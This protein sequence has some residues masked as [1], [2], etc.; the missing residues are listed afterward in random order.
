MV[1]T[2]F[3][4]EWSSDNNVLKF[5]STLDAFTR[6]HITG[7]EIWFNQAHSMHNSYFKAHPA[8]QNVD[9]D[10]CV[11]PTHAAYGDGEEFEPRYLEEIRAA[12]WKNAVGVSLKRGD[13]IVLDNMAVQ[14]ARL[15][16]KGDRK[17]A[18][19]LLN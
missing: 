7:E 12:G 13:L 11:F 9:T 14:H 2:G 4:W 10:Q 17:M 19:A 8:F 18:L 1:D 16:F 15:S 6:H 5:W 3:E